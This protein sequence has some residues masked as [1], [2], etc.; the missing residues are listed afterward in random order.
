M[1]ILKLFNLY[2]KEIQINIKGTIEDPLFQANQIGKLLT[3]KNIRSTIEKF[4]EDEKKD[5]VDTIDTI[6]RKQKATFLTEIGLYHQ[7]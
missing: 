5:D 4:D 3:I 1:D 2:D 6:G 7:S